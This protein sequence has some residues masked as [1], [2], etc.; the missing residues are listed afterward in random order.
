MI[1]WWD[2]TTLFI[3]VFR[4][5]SLSSLESL[6]DLVQNTA[7]PHPPDRTTLVIIFYY[8]L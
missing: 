3:I 8:P 1:T 2:C 4:V 7:T 5:S 6:M